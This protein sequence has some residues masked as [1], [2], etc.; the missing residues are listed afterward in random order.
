MATR[1]CPGAWRE[2]CVAQVDQAVATAQREPAPDPFAESWESLS[3]S[4]LSETV[5]RN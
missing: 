1:S 3:T 5:M 2:E 4:R